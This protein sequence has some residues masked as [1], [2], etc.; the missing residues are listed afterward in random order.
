MRKTTKEVI[1][2]AGLLI[3]APSAQAQSLA[4]ATSPDGA[5]NVEVSIDGD[6]RAAYAVNRKG[7]AILSSSEQE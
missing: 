6:G 2:T 7:K 1:A 4:S 3:L 5:I